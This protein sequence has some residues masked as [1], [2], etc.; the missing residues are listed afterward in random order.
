MLLRI[1]AAAVLSAG[2]AWLLVPALE[3]PEEPA[4]VQASTPSETMVAGKA[5]T[6]RWAEP[7]A[8]A[9]TSSAAPQSPV[10]QSAAV[11]AQEPDLKAA[12]PAQ[13][14]ADGL[15]RWVDTRQ[16]AIGGATPAAAPATAATATGSAWTPA[17]PAADARS[18]A[19]AS[20][21]PAAGSGD[22]TPA[23]RRKPLARERTTERNPGSKAL[24]HYYE[25][26]G[27]RGF[28]ENRVRRACVPGLR[29]PQV[30]YYPQNIRRNFPVRAG[31]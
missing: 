3:S 26:T 16:L 30:C 21:E 18:N 20:A 24:G 31:D 1:F 28:G 29:M 11:K 22:G 2:I 12:V 23:A 25:I 4:A 13:F 15:P 8:P 6:E 5:I 19:K 17:Q 9:A 7:D 14:N 27:A 10:P